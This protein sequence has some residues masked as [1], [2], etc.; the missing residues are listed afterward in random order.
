MA[1][2]LQPTSEKQIAPISPNEAQQLGWSTALVPFGASLCEGEGPISELS[3]PLDNG[4]LVDGPLD[5]GAQF[6]TELGQEANREN[7]YP[8]FAK[9]RA[10][11]PVLDTGGNTWFTFNHES[12]HQL[13]RAK[14]VS[15]DGTKS[16]LFKKQLANNPQLQEVADRSKSM[17][18]LD[19]P[20]HTRLRKLVSA[21]FTPR[22][23]ERLSDRV[24][25]LTDGLLDHMANKG[26]VD[27]LTEFAYPLP[28]A[29]ICELLGIPASDEA[30][31]GQWSETLTKGLDPE[32]FISDED[33]K[34]I[35]VARVELEAYTRDL[36]PRRRQD[37]GD[38]LISGLL[39]AQQ[40]GD[41]LTE[42]ELISMVI[43]LLVAGHETT[44]NL[45][46]NGTVALLKNRDQLEKLR[47]D[48]TLEKNATDELL[49]FDSPVQFSGRNL[50]EPMELNGIEIPVGDQIITL[51]GGA[52]RDPAVFDDPDS[53]QLDRPNANRHMSFGGGIHHCLGAALARLEGQIAIGRLVRRFDKLALAAEPKVGPR[54]VLRGYK[55]IIVSV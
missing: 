53:L 50:L 40:D 37:P 43:L 51:L 25:T 18:F 7:P 31:F 34:A 45:I 11:T 30:I 19:A 32:I 13:L 1:L 6:L 27:L 33:Q 3:Q 48:P 2:R 16:T 10:N 42:E 35:E 55:S 38:D 20:E 21:A 23:V 12:A 15:S 39:H 17:L 28:V 5:D 41:Q 44:V 46:G 52:N 4:Q 8:L 47:L 29:V 24:V 14:N 22:T 9:M 36:L 26:E 54:I 49:R